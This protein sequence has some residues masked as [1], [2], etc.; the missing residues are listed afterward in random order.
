MKKCLV[1]GEVLYDIYPTH[2]KIGGAPL[3]FGAHFA[4]LGGVSYLCSAVGD[5]MLADELLSEVKELGFDTSLVSVIPGVPTAYCRV[6][7]NGDEPVYTLPLGVS[8][9]F[10]SCDAVTLEPDLVY[11]GTLA[12]R[13]ETSLKALRTLLSGKSAAFK[14]FDVNIRQSFYSSELIKELLVYA[15]G[16][17]LNRDEYE[18]CNSALGINADSVEE[19][20]KKLSELY[21][22]RICLVTLDKDG[23]AL[24]E[25]ESGRFST[26]PIKDGSFV[27]AV[28]AGDSF[29]ACFMYNYLGGADIGAAQ[30]SATSLA[31]LVVGVEAAVPEYDAKDF[32]NA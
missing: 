5:D 29:S 32:V 19:F 25:R 10:I 3:N 31:S 20:S 30:E 22:L 6:T 9:D 7:Y 26:M 12:V 8:Y 16:V 1:F 23:S 2:K 21:S 4:R 27:S 17:K 28:G 13:S 11:Y 18:Y 24:Y 14:F 15:D